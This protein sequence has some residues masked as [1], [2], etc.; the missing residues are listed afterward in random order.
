[1]FGAEVVGPSELAVQGGVRYGGR[2]CAE[3]ERC[4]V[5]ETVSEWV[6]RPVFILDKGKKMIRGKHP[7]FTESYE[8]QERRDGE[9]G[10]RLLVRMK[11]GM[12][13]VDPPPMIVFL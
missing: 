2:H 3:E 12:G 11:D 10:N 1:M 9:E 4:R 8:Q 7:W 13:F 6:R 5:W